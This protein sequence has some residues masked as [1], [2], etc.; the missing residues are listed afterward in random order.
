MELDL[1][2]LARRLATRGVAVSAAHL[3]DALPAAWAHHDALVER[4]IQHPWHGLVTRLLEGAG[5]PD[6]APHVEWLWSEQPRANLWRKPIRS[7]VAVARELAAAG[8]RVAVLSNSEGRI[9]ELLAEVGIADPFCHVVDSGRLPFAKPDR[10]IFAHA[11][12]LCLGDEAPDSLPIHI[13]DSWAADIAGARDAGWRAVWYG[14]HARP[15]DD[16]LVACARDG[17]ELRAALARWL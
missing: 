9:A 10:R 1:D 6:P 3:V 13:G 15:V 4:G 14:A 2:F 11:R 16:P 12:T 8:H 7:V 17:E 5:V